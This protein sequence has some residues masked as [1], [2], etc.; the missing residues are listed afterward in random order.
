MKT[1]RALIPLLGVLLLFSSC[2]ASPLP[3]GPGIGL[4]AGN[5]TV[6]V[7]NALTQQPIAGARVSLKQDGRNVAAD[8]ASDN[9]GTAVFQSVLSGSGYKAFAGSV[10]G[11]TPGASPAIKMETDTE[12]VIPMAP[13]VNQGEGLVAGSV[14]D[15]TTQAPL[16]GVTVTLGTGVQQ[17][18]VPRRIQPF[19]IRQLGGM[20]AQTDASGQFTFNSVLPGSYQVSFTGGAGYQ[21]ATRQLQVNPGETATI[22]T[23]FLSNGSGT[24]GP[25]GPGDPNSQGHVLIVDAGRAVQLNGQAQIAWRYP[26]TA[27]SAATR[28]PDNTTVVADEQVNQ[29]WIIGPNGEVI[30]NM[31]SSLGLFSRLSAPGWVAAARDGKSFLIT[32]SGNNRILEIENGQAGWRF[33]GLVRPRSATYA[34]NGNVLIADTGNRRVIEVDRAGQV[35]WTFN[36]EMQAPVHAVRLDDGRTVITDNAYNRVIV[37]S[38][39]GQAGLLFENG[40]MRPRSTIPTRFGTFLVSDTGNN[41]VVEIDGSGQVVGTIPN[42]VRP[43]SAERL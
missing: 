27:I 40:L 12:V 13:S 43:Q 9:S 25:I 1:L 6:R 34:A 20:T 42:L 4:P 38:P 3:G 10:N 39:T 19:A 16:P 15:A 26:G 24:P 30:W 11:Y 29:V 2:G 5:L 32:D 23:V 21:P 17:M 37:V 8:V 18:G 41:R 22:E 36:R 14:K 33:E 35:V 7:I 28:L 31:G